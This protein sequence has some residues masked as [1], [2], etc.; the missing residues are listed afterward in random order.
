MPGVDEMPF[1]RWQAAMSENLLYQLQYRFSIDGRAHISDTP[2][3]G[4]SRLVELGGTGAED[5]TNLVPPVVDS[6]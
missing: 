5:R 6:E 2:V 1:S 3:R 4:T